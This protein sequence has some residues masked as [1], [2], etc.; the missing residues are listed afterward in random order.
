MKEGSDFIELTVFMPVYNGEYYI[1]DT[2]KSILEQSYDDFEFLIIDDGST[3]STI[4]EI[5]KFTD[6]RI[7]VIKNNQNKGLPYTRNLGLELSKGTFIAF[8]DSDDI[9][10]KDRLKIQ[11]NL[12][13]EQ[14]HI[15]IVSCRVKSISKEYTYLDA[16]NDMKE[17]KVEKNMKYF[18][19]LN[20][21]PNIEISLLFT[22]IMNNPGSMIRMSKI[23]E[24]KLSYRDE[25]TVAQDYS[26]WVDCQNKNLYFHILN[27][28]LVFYRS[29][30]SNIT[31][32]SKKHKP[33]FRS[34]LVDSIRVRALKNNGFLLETH[35]LDLFCEIN[36]ED[37]NSIYILKDILKYKII[38]KELVEI[39]YEKE[40]FDHKSFK[41]MIQIFWCNFIVINTQL[42]K[43]DKFKFIMNDSFD[44]SSNSIVYNLRMFFKK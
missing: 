25:F 12:L 28:N 32:S 5:E 6:D 21:H 10:H 16:Q 24:A 13:R 43:K 31:A 35:Q 37:N 1:G 11:L 2:I 41:Y 7:R 44:K 30:H 38:L 9:A 23:K 18:P 22:C 29:G 33:K 17:Y 39:N 42:S 34:E 36:K 15:D 27:E 8:M 19:N 40:S 3:D 20:K 14:K 26:F 4:L